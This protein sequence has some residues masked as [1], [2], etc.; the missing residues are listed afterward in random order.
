MSSQSSSSQSSPSQS[1]Q[2]S[3]ASSFQSPPRI[4]ER[5]ARP[6]V[7]IRASVTMAEIADALPPLTAEVLAWLKARGVSP[8][9]PELWRYLTIDMAGELTIDVGFPVAEPLDGDDRVLSGELPGGPYAV[10]LFHGHPDGLM[11]AT[12]D[13]LRWG[14]ETGV[15]WDTHPDGPGEA[16]GSRIEWYLNSEEPDLDAWDTELAFLTSARPGTAPATPAAGS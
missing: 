4:E 9:G 16:W 7:A 1:S 6:Y 12:A 8:D 3:S 13:L 10:A 14:E 11:Q 5:P 2:P 15:T